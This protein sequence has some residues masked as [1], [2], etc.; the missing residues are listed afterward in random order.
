MQ[1]LNVY[2]EAQQSQPVFIS[3]LKIVRRHRDA[4][5]EFRLRLGVIALTHV[6][7]TEQDMSQGIVWFLTHVIAGRRKRLSIFRHVDERLDL[8][9]QDSDVGWILADHHAV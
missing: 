3:R 7:G 2:S 5:L 4:E 9:A 1:S 6:H 8:G